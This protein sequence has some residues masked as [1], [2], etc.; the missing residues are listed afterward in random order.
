MSEDVV[1]S[2]RVFAIL[3]NITSLASICMLAKVSHFW[4]GH[5]AACNVVVPHEVDRVS[6]HIL[7]GFD[8]I[9]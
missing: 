8:V 4:L 7:Y 5:T 3:Y 2:T 9:F 6:L 1:T